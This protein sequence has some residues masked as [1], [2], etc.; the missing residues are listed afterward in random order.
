M[1]Y[2]YVARFRG[3][4]GRYAV[5]W[6]GSAP[7]GAV[8]AGIVSGDRELSGSAWR[9]SL[10]GQKIIGAPGQAAYERQVSRYHNRPDPETGLMLNEMYRTFSAGELVSIRPL[11]D[12]APASEGAPCLCGERPAAYCGSGHGCEVSDG[13]A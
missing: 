3:V 11:G 12:G 9:Y 8:L 2:T 7:S 5:S 10:G 1:S 4:P 13:R 6:E